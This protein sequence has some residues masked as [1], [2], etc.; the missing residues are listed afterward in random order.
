V[1][2]TSESALESQ[3]HQTAPLAV[4]THLVDRCRG[5]SPR[6]KGG[7]SLQARKKADCPCRRAEAREMISKPIIIFLD[8]EI[9]REI[10]RPS[11]LLSED[12]CERSIALLSESI[13]A[14]EGSHRAGF[15]TPLS[16]ALWERQSQTQFPSPIRRTQ[17]LLPAIVR[18]GAL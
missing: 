5:L 14:R 15:H 8:T 18:L 1:T 2:G 16:R 6:R 17:R 13:C 3:R 4:D 10:I 9:W 7:L 11:V 12:G